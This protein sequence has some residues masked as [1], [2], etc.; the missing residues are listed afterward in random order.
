MNILMEIEYDGTDYA[1]WQFQPHHRTIQ[2]ELEKA[3]R[4]ILQTQIKIISASRTDA[5]VSAQGQITN[6]HITNLR[7]ENITKFKNSLN[8]V[9]PD[10]I[11]I[12]SIKIVTDKFHARFS[13][14]S[15]VYE[16]RILI[17]PAPLRQRFAW[18]LLYK[19]NIANVRKAIKLFLK[20]TDYKKFCKVRDKDGHVV[21]KSISIKKTKDEILIRIEANR[22]L[23]KMVR[24]IVGALVEVGRGHRTDQDIKDCLAGGNHRT[25]VCAPANGLKLVKVKY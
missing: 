22:F 4:Q 15:K 5:G 9:L 16:Y 14:K 3:L 8:A 18:V 19:L 13:T 10:D 7:F 1:G 2:G 25:L 20:Q 21:M 6:F 11:F 12:K 23:Y 17:T 24:R